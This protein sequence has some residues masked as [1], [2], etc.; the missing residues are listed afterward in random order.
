MPSTAQS[1]LYIL[2]SEE[3]A[4]FYHKYLLPIVGRAPQDSENKYDLLQ[5]HIEKITIPEC[6]IAVLGIQGAGKSS[7]LN[8]VIFEDEVLPVEV[9]E[10]TCIPTMIRRIYSG[11]QAGAE[12]HYQNDKVETIPL[13]KEFIEKIVDNRYNPGNIMNVAFVVCRVDMPFLREG[14][15]FVD[16]PGVGSLTEKNEETTMMFLQ[17]A[18]I[19]IFL[20]RTV[21]PITDSEAGFI[22]IAWPRL[23]DSIFVQNLWA[24]ETEAEVKGGIGHNESVLRTIA[25]EQ[26]TTPPSVIVPVNVAMA[27]QGAYSGDE[28]KINRSRIKEL[29]KHIRMFAR[30]SALEN[31]YRETAKMFIRLLQ[32]GQHQ[33]ADRIEALEGS[34]ENLSQQF[35][36]AKE[37]F[38]ANRER[39]EDYVNRNCEA[40]LENSAELKSDWLPQLLDSTSE[41][42]LQK[43]DRLPIEDMKEDEFRQEVREV[44]S[45]LFGNAY[46]QIKEKLA[47]LAENHV[48]NLGQSLQ[49]M[50]SISQVLQQGFCAQ[51]EQQ[52]GASGWSVALSGSIA[53]LVVSGPVGWG[54]LGGA[55]VTGG[56][57]RWASGATAHKRIMRGVRKSI[58]DGKRQ[59]RKE[60]ITEIDYFS[61]QVIAAIKQSVEYE[62]NA[63]YDELVKL[64]SDLQQKEDAQEILKSELYEDLKLADFFIER[65]GRLEEPE[66][67][68]GQS[69]QDEQEA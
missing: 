58:G 68:A 1:L 10:T 63:Y 65:L 6:F 2:E 4:Q 55:I 5:S 41:E 3:F 15:V 46:K 62:L 67:E 60:M 38:I 23:Q 34:Q 16:L 52:K 20:L 56:V 48:E 13:K 53:P 49:Q 57:V 24:Q 54:I 18:H 14:F 39:L 61:E 28:L 19:G 69:E 31:L 11:E 30:R 8:A 36:Q 33:I 7:L 43:I 50:A 35:A 40:F 45:E 29:K 51:P 17:D 42:C 66:P 12:V 44:F 27:C 32:K 21:P 59:I 26:N 37:K 47:H 25:R 22:R 9:Q 64:Q